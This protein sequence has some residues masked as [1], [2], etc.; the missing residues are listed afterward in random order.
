MTLRGIQGGRKGCS[1]LIYRSGKGSCN[2]AHRR[3]IPDMQSPGVEESASDLVVTT[4][5]RGQRSKTVHDVHTPP[6]LMSECVR[7]VR[8]HTSVAAPMSDEGS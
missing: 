6:L 2:A 1:S 5:R 4:V 7:C 8:F 3:N